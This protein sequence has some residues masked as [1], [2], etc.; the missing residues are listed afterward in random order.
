MIAPKTKVQ[1]SSNSQNA[2]P[3]YST[4]KDVVTIDLDTIDHRLY[5]HRSL[6]VLMYVFDEPLFLSFLSKFLHHRIYYTVKSLFTQNLP[7]KWY[8]AKQN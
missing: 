6:S 5:I 3:N 8:L 2:G 1:N 7:W 4:C